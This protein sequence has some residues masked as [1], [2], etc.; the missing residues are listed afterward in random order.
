MKYIN[1]MRNHNTL[2]IIDNIDL[3][4]FGI[5]LHDMKSIEDFQKKSGMSGAYT[6]EYQ[7]HYIAAI[8]RI[9][10]EGQILDIAIPMAMYNYHQRVSGAAIEFHLNDVTTANEK[11]MP[12]AIKKFNEFNKTPFFKQL[13]EMGVTGW[14]ISGF[15]SN[16]QH[17]AGVDGFSGVD[18]RSNI[19]NPGV[20][21]PLSEGNRSPN[22]AGIMQH[23]ELHSEIIR[24]EYR[25]FTGSKGKNKIYSKGRC[26]TIVRGYE[27]EPEEQIQVLPDGLI[28]KIFGT[29]RPKPKPKP[30][31]KTRADYM[32]KDQLF[33]EEGEAIGRELMELW[34]KCE[35]EIDTSMIEEENVVRNGYNYRK[36]Q[37]SLL[38]MDYEDQYEI[39]S[40]EFKREKI[41]KKEDG[42]KRDISNQWAVEIERMAM[43][44][45][46]LLDYKEEEVRTWT[47]FEVRDTYNLDIED[48]NLEKALL[49]DIEKTS[50]NGLMLKAI[51]IL[52]RD[53]IMGKEKLE[54]L[55]YTD[56]NDLFVETYETD[57][58]ILE[59][60]QV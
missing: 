40:K 31:E 46:D 5:L 28:D 14:E 22:F 24:T 23:K 53:N 35:F 25:V 37:T 29:S 32:L 36:K 42:N 10:A 7:H 59:D 17:P 49:R 6:V 52:C 26:L 55:N 33:N 18:L 12:I 41:L 43:E 50:K 44:L 21:F 3:N 45:V 58:E 38:G 1:P 34:K 15:H 11:A 48:I 19:D 8:G 20:C 16:H 56:L 27:N 4:N 13:N 60:M 9:E 30:K 47:A 54:M 2:Q 39:L 57:M 51:D